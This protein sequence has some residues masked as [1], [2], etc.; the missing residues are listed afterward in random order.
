MISG[1]YPACEITSGLARLSLVTST[2]E[3]GCGRRITFPEHDLEA[4]LLGIGLVG[5][6]DADAI[7][8]IL[9]DQRDLD[10]LG[11]HPEFRLGVLGDEAGEGLAVLI[12][13]NLGAEDVFQVLVRERR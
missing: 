6:G 8:A 7:G 9:V 4:G 10:V 12:G 5:G 13:I 1:L 11:L 2:E 3:V